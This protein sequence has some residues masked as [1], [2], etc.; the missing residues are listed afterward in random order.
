MSPIISRA[1]SCI[2]ALQLLQGGPAVGATAVFTMCFVNL[3]TRFLLTHSPP[4]PSSEAEAELLCSGVQ[5]R[6]QSSTAPWQVW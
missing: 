6:T 5:H 1:L 2:P 4:P 3:F